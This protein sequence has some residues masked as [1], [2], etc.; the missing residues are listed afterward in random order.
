M[1]TSYRLSVGQLDEK[2]LRSVKALFTHPEEE[3][4]I[5]VRTARDDTTYLLA[6]DANR[7]HL[8]LALKDA[9]AGRNL[10]DVPVRELEALL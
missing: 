7:E 5:T 8:E 2:F 3:I 6:A 1:Q 4:E 9:A 10:K